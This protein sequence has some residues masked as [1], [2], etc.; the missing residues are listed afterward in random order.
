ML[1]EKAI[2]EFRPECTGLQE[3]IS[4][5]RR[6]IYELSPDSGDH[7][8]YLTGTE[9]ENPALLRDSQRLKVEWG[10]RERVFSILDECLKE[11]SIGMSIIWLCG[12]DFK[13]SFQKDQNNYKDIDERKFS[14]RWIDHIDSFHSIWQLIKHIPCQSVQ[15]FNP[16]KLIEM[17]KLR[18]CEFQY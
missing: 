16:S 5:W 18:R 10:G 13:N 17:F 14:C 6:C 8:L 3:M 1:P 12:S 9:A 4:N 2:L 11:L 15:F 7:W